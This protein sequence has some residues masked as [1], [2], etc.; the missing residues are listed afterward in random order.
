MATDSPEQTFAARIFAELADLRDE[1]KVVRE[2]VIRMETHGYG[3]Q[4]EELR[5]DTRDTR[6]KVL[7]IETKGKMAAGVVAAGVSVISM[8]I[9]GLV[10]YAL[11]VPVHIG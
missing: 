1:I 5:K 8:V 9:G 10:L 6:E 2:S 4:I 3:L 11:N 7:V